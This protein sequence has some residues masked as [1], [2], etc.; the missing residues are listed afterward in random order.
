MTTGLNV[1]AG[2]MGALRRPCGWLWMGRGESGWRGWLC[3]GPGGSVLAVGDGSGWAGGQC[4]GG[5][6][7]WIDWWFADEEAEDLADFISFQA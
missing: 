2:S 6:A 3:A 7:E 5:G 4:R 1:M